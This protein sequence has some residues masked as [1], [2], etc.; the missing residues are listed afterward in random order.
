MMSQ[1]NVCY[2]VFNFFIATQSQMD[3]PHRVFDLCFSV[4]VSNDVVVSFLRQQ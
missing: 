2:I 3:S 4:D 1:R